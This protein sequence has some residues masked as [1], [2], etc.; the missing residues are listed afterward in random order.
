MID[1]NRRRDILCIFIF[2]KLKRINLIITFGKLLCKGLKSIINFKIAI[3]PGR[4]S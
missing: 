3:K 2:L 1:A 4:F